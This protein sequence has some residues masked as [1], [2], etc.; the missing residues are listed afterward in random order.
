MP[1]YVNPDLKP[2]GPKKVLH[3][4]DAAFAL[5]DDFD[6]TIRDA[7]TLFL[8]YHSKAVSE[9]KVGTPV[10][11]S[12]LFTSMGILSISPP[13]IKCCLEAKLYKLDKDGHYIEYIPKEEK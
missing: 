10:D 7:L 4:S 9:N 5:P 1:Q 2:K 13:D 3:I 6:G 11:P 8:E 12:R